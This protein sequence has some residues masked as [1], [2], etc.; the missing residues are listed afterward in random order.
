MLKLIGNS[1][2]MKC[3]NN[4]KNRGHQLEG[5]RWCYRKDW[6]KGGNMRRKIK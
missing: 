2:K 3:S 5:M 6:K 4:Q 1:I